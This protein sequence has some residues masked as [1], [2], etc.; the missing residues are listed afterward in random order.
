MT[1][2][3][4]IPVTVLRSLGRKDANSQHTDTGMWLHSTLEEFIW[5][6]IFTVIKPGL[7]PPLQGAWGLE[8]SSPGGWLEQR[9][10]GR[11]QIQAPRAED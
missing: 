4:F 1:A 3:S 9:Q 5:C 8:S 11:R 6:T 10:G 2:D 7:G